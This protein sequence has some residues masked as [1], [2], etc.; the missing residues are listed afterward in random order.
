MTTRKG[1]MHCNCMLDTFLV[2]CPYSSVSALHQN[3][4]LNCS[5]ISCQDCICSGSILSRLKMLFPLF[6]VWLSKTKENVLIM[7]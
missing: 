3:S 2:I 6:W 5:L 7:S 1:K 4:H